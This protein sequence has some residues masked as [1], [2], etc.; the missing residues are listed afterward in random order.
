LKNVIKER[1]GDSTIVATVLLMAITLFCISLTLNFVQTSLARHDGENDFTLSQ[2][3]MKNIGLSVDDVAWHPGQSNTIQYSS[4]SAE[5]NLRPSL[6]HYKIEVWKVGDHSYSTLKEYD[7]AVL[8][9]DLPLTKYYLDNTYFDNILPS[10]MTQLIQNSTEAPITRVFSVQR[11]PIV[12]ENA[13]IKTCVA[14]LFR[15]VQFNINANGASTSYLKLYLANMTLGPLTTA[16][17]RYI[18]L[19]GKNVGASVINNVLHLRVSVSFPSSVS[20][21]NST[22]FNFPVTSQT[23]DFPITGSEVELYVGTVQVGFLE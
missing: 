6:I 2:T 21:Y 1:R 7:T 19:T 18:T 9:Y 13:Y 22:F 14:S 11:A 12:G 8:F 17:P 23:I 20:G 15:S 4:E 5:I 3:F 16:N 10:N